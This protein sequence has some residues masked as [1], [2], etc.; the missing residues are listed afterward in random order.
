M[1]SPE[2]SERLLRV[3]AATLD[4]ARHFQQTLGEESRLAL[5]EWDSAVAAL[6]RSDGEGTSSR[7]E[8]GGTG[9]E[10][11]ALRDNAKRHCS[12]GGGNAGGGGGDGAQEASGQLAARPLSAATPRSELLRRA[13]LAR[14]GV[15][16]AFAEMANSVPS[17]FLPVI[18]SEVVS[19]L[20]AAA[21][22]GA[23]GEAAAGGDDAVDRL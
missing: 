15:A 6:R 3:R 1:F 18:S 10:E 11:A 17:V 20:T 23:Q 4:Q 19:H 14:R 12:R 7:G 8:G 13:A 22:G 5:L 21:A 2:R 16:D 9:A